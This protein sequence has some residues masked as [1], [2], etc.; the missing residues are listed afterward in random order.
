[1][2]SRNSRCKKKQ[3]NGTK[4]ELLLFFAR[5]LVTILPEGGSNTKLTREKKGTKNET[6]K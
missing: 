4:R 3:G 6:K 1:M 2:V 5:Y